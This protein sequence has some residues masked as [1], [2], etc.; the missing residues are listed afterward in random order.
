MKMK[1]PDHICPVC[2][3]NQQCKKNIPMEQYNGI[4]VI[5]DMWYCPV[6]KEAWHEKRY[7]R[8]LRTKLC[9]GHFYKNGKPVKFQIFNGMCVMPQTEPRQHK[10]PR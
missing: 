2:G 9:N 1:E 7:P 8:W 4:V 6:A 3:G 10:K 5:C